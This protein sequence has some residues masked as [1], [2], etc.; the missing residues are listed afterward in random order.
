MRDL[1]FSVT[2]CDIS[3]FL[4]YHH[5]RREILA[6]YS[7]NFIQKGFLFYYS[8]NSSAISSTR[9]SNSSGICFY[10]EMGPSFFQWV[11][12]IA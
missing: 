3:T 2:A 4:N 8:S 6:I 11:P 12:S 7:N 10:R 1:R 9:G 5:V